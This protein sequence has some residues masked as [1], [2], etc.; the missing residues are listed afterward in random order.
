MWSA[1]QPLA[2]VGLL[3]AATLLLLSLGA[4]DAP[5]SSFLEEEEVEEVEAPL[6]SESDVALD[7][8]AVVLAGT[9]VED[10]ERLSV[11]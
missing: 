1:D 2:F 10:L 11:T 9:A 3:L 4:L 7:E 5:P 6:A 8:D